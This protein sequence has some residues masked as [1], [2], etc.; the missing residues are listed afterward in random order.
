MSFCPSLSSADEFVSTVQDAVDKVFYSVKGTGS[1]R[2]ME[3]ILN[4]SM[5]T[6]SH[7][8][9]AKLLKQQL[10]LGRAQARMRLRTGMLPPTT[11]LDFDT[12]MGDSGREL[13]APGQNPRSDTDP[14]QD[15]SCC[16]VFDTILIQ[17]LAAFCN[18]SARHYKAYHI[19]MDLSNDLLNTL[20][21]SSQQGRAMR[22]FFT[23]QTYD[24]VVRLKGQAQADDKTIRGAR[25]WGVRVTARTVDGLVFGWFEDPVHGFRRCW[26]SE[27]LKRTT[28]EAR[29][30]RSLTDGA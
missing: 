23:L 5:F 8:A 25:E 28:G 21:A 12:G 15:S 24:A 30:A 13:R 9:K 6:E 11:T 26:V 18:V 1:A 2:L 29:G 22:P 14:R 20:P 3:R 17:Q 4:Q 10:A 27:S 7:Q 19:D 16:F